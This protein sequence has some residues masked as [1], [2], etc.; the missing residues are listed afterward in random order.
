MRI[1]V[2]SKYD[3]ED[4]MKR[5]QVNNNTVETHDDSFFISIHHSNTNPDSCY[6]QNKSNVKVLFFDD[7]YVDE[8]HAKAIT[9]EQAM[10]LLD[11]IDEHKDKDYCYVHC[12]AG[13]SR[14]G[15]VGAFICDYT[16]SDWN[17]FITDNPQIHP[18]ITV[19]RAL[20]HAVK[21]KHNLQ[22][23]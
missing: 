15:A 18:N 12:A 1:L 20:K 3:F 6:F 4:V 17:V 22:M 7:C 10:E 23:Y 13:I 14:S 2:F 19:L 5:S 21:K 8:E 9:E 16:E 11:F